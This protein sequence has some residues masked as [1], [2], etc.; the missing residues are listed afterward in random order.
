VAA[1]AEADSEEED[2]AVAT[3]ATVEET[4]VATVEE[5]EE[6]DSEATVAVATVAVATVADSE[7][8]R[9]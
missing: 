8:R 6:A 1:M 7:S 3:V 9:S 5:T 4:E 2:S